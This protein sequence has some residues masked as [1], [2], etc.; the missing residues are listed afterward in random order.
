M[1]ELEVSEPNQAGRPPG[2]E[3][4]LLLLPGLDG[5]GR[6]FSPL[7]GSLPAFLRP[8]TVAYA[9]E[10]LLTYTQLQ[11]Q[12]EKELP[13]ARPFALLG[14]SFSGPIAIRIAANGPVGLVCLVLV[15]TFDWSP[16]HS[17]PRP[18][19]RGAAHIAVVLRSTEAMRRILAGRDVPA[20]LLV[21]IDSV[22]RS[23][24]APLLRRRLMDALAADARAEFQAVNLPILYLGGRR[25]L[26]VPRFIPKAMMRRQPRMEY[27]WLDAPHMVLQCR[28][29]EAARAIGEF[30]G[31]AVASYRG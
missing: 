9:N 24:G 10:K 31:C 3:V 26:L 20:T 13:A 18:I 21:E 17:L 12:V 29:A 27:M 25:D 2:P 7:L 16:L 5:T 14:E 22:A 11:E 4:E 8:R 28:P 30:V 6:L 23:V 1:T 15:A 19:L